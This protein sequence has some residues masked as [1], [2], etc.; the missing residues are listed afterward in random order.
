MVQNRCVQLISR[1]FIFALMVA[2]TVLSLGA[3]KFEN[4]WYVYYTNLSNYLCLFCVFAEIVI[5]IYKIQKNSPNGVGDIHPAIKFSILIDIAVTFFVFN[6]L[7]VDKTNNLFTA[8]YWKNPNSVLLHFVCPLL[9]FI[10][11]LIFG[12]HDSTKWFYPFLVLIFPLIYV[13]A[14]L[15]RG[16]IIFKTA[17]AWQIVYPYFFL[18]VPSIGYAKVFM[19]VGILIA[20]F[21]V[22]SYIVM[23]FDRLK[24]IKGHHKKS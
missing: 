13:G 15:I 19:W 23:F 4:N 10:D 5:T 1:I 11:W 16:S 9:F 14:I 20:V 2:G 7:L 22:F 24:T 6:I 18:D 12:K 8:N 21:L 3:G 17:P